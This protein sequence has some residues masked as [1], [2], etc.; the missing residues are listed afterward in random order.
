MKWQV[1]GD[2]IWEVAGGPDHHMGPQRPRE[3]ACILF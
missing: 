2:E 3:G 1:L